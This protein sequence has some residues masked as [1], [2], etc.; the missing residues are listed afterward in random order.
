MGLII[1]AYLGIVFGVIT[2]LLLLFF[3]IE[4]SMN[5]R[6]LTSWRQ[7]VDQ[8]ILRIW[9]IVI[10][11]MHIMFRIFKRGSSAFEAD[12]IDP[13]TDPIVDTY[14]K[15]EVIRTGKFHIRKKSPG[16]LSPHL[17]HLLEKRM[18]VGRRIVIVKNNK[19]AD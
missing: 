6:F 2:L 7:S 17:Q 13:V 10:R 3:R 12:L 14:K 4:A 19:D 5:R 9:K 8:K 11:Y 16:K 15:Y 1:V 18:M